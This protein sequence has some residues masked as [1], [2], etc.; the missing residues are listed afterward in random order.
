[1]HLHDG[2]AVGGRLDAGGGVDFFEGGEMG[3]GL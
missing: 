2:V 1:M 3:D